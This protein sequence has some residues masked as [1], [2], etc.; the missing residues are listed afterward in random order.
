MK[1]V[2]SVA[3]ALA[4]A[5]SVVP[6][7][8][9]DTFQAFGKMSTGEQKFVTP[10]TDEQLAAIEGEAVKVCIDCTNVARVRQTNVAIKSFKTYQSNAS[11]V[12]QSNN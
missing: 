6:A 2:I 11:L 9:E 7:M 12:F 8:A 10:L 5:L 1:I 3:I 4:L